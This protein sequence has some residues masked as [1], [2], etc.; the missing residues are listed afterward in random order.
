MSK[1]KYQKMQEIIPEIKEMLKAGKTQQEV[2]R[3]F[4]LTGN[5]PIHQLLMRENRKARKLAAG[6]I[7]RSKG[8]PCKDAA[9]RDI[10]AEQ[11]YEIKRL[12]MENKLLRD[13]L[14]LT[15][16]K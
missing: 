4:G 10:F 8:R 14:Q 3:H 11:E 2:E 13:F 1:R 12:K 15:G 6:I 16:R 7:P 9:P 5:R